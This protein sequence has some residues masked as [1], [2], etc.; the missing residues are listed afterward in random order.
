MTTAP[1]QTALTVCFCNLRPKKN[2]TVAPKAGN[3][4][5]SQ[6]WDKKNI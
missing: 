1:T 2:M 4:G 5:M 6:M 3:S